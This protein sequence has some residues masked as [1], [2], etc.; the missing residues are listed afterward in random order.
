[1]LLAYIGLTVVCII[2][3]LL[4]WEL[5]K[6]LGYSGVETPIIGAAVWLIM[7]IGFLVSAVG[8]ARRA[9]PEGT[10]VPA[11]RWMPESAQS[12]SPGGVFH[13]PAVKF[14]S[15]GKPPGG[16]GDS[17]PSELDFDASM[18]QFEE[19]REQDASS[20]R[21]RRPPEREP[22]PLPE[23]T[24]PPSPNHEADSGGE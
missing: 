4:V 13:P 7:S 8:P 11:G 5:R 1:M 19:P 2:G 23:G 17:D 24:V 6:R 14:H 20:G 18:P 15:T 16:Q 10:T 12:R 9:N 21:R 22:S 3:T